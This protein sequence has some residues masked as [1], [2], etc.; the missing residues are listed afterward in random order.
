MLGG[1]VTSGFRLV[2]TRIGVAVGEA[3]S[4]PAAHAYVAH[5]FVAQR[6]AAPLAVIT[7]SIPVASAASLL[8]GGLLAESFGW[9]TTFVAGRRCPPWPPPQPASVRWWDLLRKPSYLAIEQ[10]ATA[11]A[12]FLFFGSTVGSVGPFLT[13]V[14]SDALTDELGTASLGRALVLVPV[15]QVIAVVLYLA[16]SRRFRTEIVEA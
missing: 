9:R 12:I 15:A 7:L 5:N 11:S 4:T 16:A 6:R 10:Y 2:L 14:F 13:G 3:G 8:G 1:V